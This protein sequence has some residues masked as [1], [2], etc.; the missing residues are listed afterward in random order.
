F[1]EEWVKYLGELEK[2]SLIVATPP[3]DAA[4]YRAR[5]SAQQ[6]DDLEGG[7]GAAEVAPTPET[8]AISIPSPPG[9][10]PGRLPTPK[11]VN[12]TPPEVPPPGR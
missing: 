6:G 3:P 7:L 10:E 8:P 9:G 2:K 1:Q 5:L 12:P 4:G 11:P